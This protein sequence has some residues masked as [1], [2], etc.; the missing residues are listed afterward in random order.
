MH[1]GIAK[2]GVRGTMTLIRDDY[3][4][5]V[6]FGNVRLVNNGTA[7]NATAN[8]NVTNILTGPRGR[9]YLFADYPGLKWCKTFLGRVPCGVRN[10]HK[11]KT[12]VRFR[13]FQKRDVL[14]NES[15]RTT[16]RLNC[17]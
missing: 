14:L 1:L 12:L 9:L 4:N 2:G 11:E 13:T 10:I 3:V 7:L 17:N 8:M 5:T 15:I 6:S 16:V